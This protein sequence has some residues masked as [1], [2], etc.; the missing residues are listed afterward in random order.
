[1]TKTSV[2]LSWRLP[3]LLSLWAAPAV[4]HWGMPDEASSISVRGG[5]EDDWI[6]G[7]PSGALISRDHGATWRWIC[8]EGMGIAI[9]RPERYFWLSGGTLLAATGSALV[10]SDD[11][12]CTWTPDAFFKDTWVTSLAMHASDEQRLY[13]STGR[14][15]LSNGLYRSEDGGGSWTLVLPPTLNSR[16]TSIRVAAS[17]PQRVYA[18]GQDVDG[19]FLTRSEDGGQ[20]WTRLPQPLTR[21]QLPYDLVLL[22]V[23]DTSPDV[24][25]A[26]VSAQG[27]DSLLKSTDG[28]ATLTPVMDTYERIASVESSEDGRT[29]WVSTT[30]RLFRGHDD[31]PFVE[32]AEPNG[33]ACSLKRGGSLYACGASWTGGWALARSADEGTTWEPM[34]RLSDVK[35]AHQCPATTP[36]QQRCPALWPQLAQLFGAPV[37][38][39]DAGVEPV[40]PTPPGEQPPPKD[41]CAAAPGWVPGALVLVAAAWGRRSRW[42]FRGRRM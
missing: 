31:E 40:T 28:G 18:S 27:R 26:R 5:H 24:L 38:G 9:W 10:R 6:M 16:F 11:A 30:T 21:F 3:L 25:W 36:V 15:S 20:T 42:S 19:Q 41:G 37:P 23:S 17:D 1:M 34:F 39:S 8:P 14:P 33:N 13:V 7:D 4:A 22:R 29:V 12:G 2:L 35:G 32:L